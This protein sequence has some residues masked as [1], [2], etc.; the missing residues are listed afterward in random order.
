MEHIVE[1]LN[2]HL[3][4]NITPAEQQELLQYVKSGKYDR[5]IRESISDYWRNN[6]G[7]VIFPED[8]KPLILNK[9]LFAEQ[10]TTALLEKTAVAK[11]RRRSLAA[12]TV[13]VLA[14]IAGAGI[15]LLRQHRP[16]A[17]PASVAVT[18]KKD[19]PPGKTGAILTLAD[20]SRIVLDSAK[21]GAVAQ[22]SG[23]R[24]VKNANGSL[25]YQATG[26]APAAEAPWNTINTPRGAQYELALPD[27]T[28]VWLNSATTLEYPV[29]FREGAAREVILSGEAYFEVAP[30]A[31]QPF[32]VAVRTRNSGFDE[33]KVLG[34][35]FNIMAYKEEA[36]VRTTLLEGSVIVSRAGDSR[37]LIP[38][39]QAIFPQGANGAIRV[40]PT[41]TEIAIA[42][43]KGFFRF[44]QCSVPAIMRQLSRWYDVDISF[45]GQSPDIIFGGGIDRNL[46]LSG[47]LGA[48]EKYGIRFET[49]GKKIRVTGKPAPGI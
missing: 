26:N 45:N 35:R 30:N 31:R 3:Q 15:L 32:K 46:P 11:R 41:D 24:I 25:A 2:K 37:Q 42:W 29:T 49:D 1:L 9:I 13:L 43:K 36:A 4:D 18:V 14:A 23:A 6:N 21:T 20:G 48:L 8:K 16:A 40:E 19:R 44:D 12:V 33:V 27:G 17:A 38:G 34:T 47:I 39:Q 22:Q 7:E 28:H 10:Q 5:I